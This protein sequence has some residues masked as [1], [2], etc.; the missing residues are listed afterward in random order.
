MDIE[1]QIKY[2]NRKTVALCIERDATI[3]VYSPHWFPIEKINE[4]IERKKWWIY[5]KLSKKDTQRKQEAPFSSWTTIPYLGKNYKLDIVDEEIKW[6]VFNQKFSLSRSNSSN[7]EKLIEIWQK[8]KALEKVRERVE[9]YSQKMG[10]SYNQIKLSNA[11]YKWWSCTASWNIIFNWKIIQLPTFVI[12]Y[13]IV[14]E[15]SHRF[16]MNHSERFWN[17]VSTHY[18]LYKKA[19]EWLKENE[20][21]IL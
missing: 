11:K 5:S 3:L 13:I 18:H 8:G 6:V 10:V 1:Y 19:K 14:H 12:D 20:L 9:H 7:A 21:F 17:I 4:F 16:E 2:G 15:L